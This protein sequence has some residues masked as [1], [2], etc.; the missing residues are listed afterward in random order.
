MQL[1]VMLAMS[2]KLALSVPHLTNEMTLPVILHL[3]ILLPEKE[4]IWAQTHARPRGIHA[5]PC[6]SDPMI[7]LS[8]LQLQE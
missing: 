5:S 7:S 6:A 1:L 8:H 3:D 2:A 4:S